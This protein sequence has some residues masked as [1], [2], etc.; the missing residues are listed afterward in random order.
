M[1][2]EIETLSPIRK[3]LHVE[4]PPDRV[5]NEFEE[6]YRKLARR[7]RLPGFRPGH[8][9]RR[10][11]EAQY[12]EAVREE[13]AAHLVRTSLQRALEEK[14]MQPVGSPEVREFA[15]T[16][17]KPFTV[18]ATVEVRPVLE[19]RDYLGVSVDRPA[20][21][22]TREEV[23]RMLESIREEHGTLKPLEGVESIAEGHW[24][25]LA[26]EAIQGGRPVEG[27][28]GKSLAVRVGRSGLGEGF[29]RA[30][31]GLRLGEARAFDAPPPG[32]TEGDDP[33]RYRVL[34]EGI[35]E[36]TLPP[37]DDEFAKDLGYASLAA[38]REG[39]Q[40]RLLEAKR[41]EAVETTKGRLLARVL[42]RNRFEVPR[43]LVDG[44]QE[45]LLRGRRP[46]PSAEAAARVR[47]IAEQRVRAA[48]I[49][50]AI[51]E[52]E[53]VSVSEEDLERLYRRRAARERTRV[54]AVRER[55]RKAGLADAARLEAR[56]EKTLEFLL[57]KARVEERA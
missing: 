13:V 47:E 19:P 29:D 18:E 41:A 39:L 17:G 20:V 10:M 5:E 49:L 30:V 52:K 44:E 3:R 38:A 33:I 34:L 16:R 53:S 56:R 42:D 1:R 26:V 7:V 36:R 32:G 48:L 24:A 22:V 6:A 37:L 54:E 57:A 25:L 8:A 40:G 27:L 50:D 55:S 2:V 15:C 14:G 45:A 12:G 11:L 21:G 31:L 35:R 23:D 43:S 4:L 51:A 9:P 46:E 28:S